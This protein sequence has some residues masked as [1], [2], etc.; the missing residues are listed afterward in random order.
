MQKK[1]GKAC[2]YFFYKYKLLEEIQRFLQVHKYVSYVHNKFQ[3][4][5]LL[6]NANMPSFCRVCEHVRQRGVANVIPK[7]CIK[8]YLAL[9]TYAHTHTQQEQQQWRRQREGEIERGTKS[10]AAQRPALWRFNLRYARATAERAIRICRLLLLC[11]LQRLL[12]SEVDN[13]R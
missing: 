9:C 7:L 12:W 5:V 8:V 13:T 10:E 2:S 4:T 6:H 1:K 11:K 3:L